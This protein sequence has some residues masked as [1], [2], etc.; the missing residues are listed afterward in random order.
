LDLGKPPKNLADMAHLNMAPLALI[1]F[2]VKT[3]N[4]QAQ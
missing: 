1:A 2:A 4:A 3:Q